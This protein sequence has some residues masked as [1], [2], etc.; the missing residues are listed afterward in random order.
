[1][2]GIDNL[3]FTINLL[4]FLFSRDWLHRGRRGTASSAQATNMDPTPAVRVC[5]FTSTAESYF[6]AADCQGI[7]GRRHRSFPSRFELLTDLEPIHD[8]R[9][10]S[11]DKSDALQMLSRRLMAPV[12]AKRLE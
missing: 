4:R 10:E 1:M 5:I 12:D 9:P 11:A 6:A 7:E 2:G 3:R 8:S